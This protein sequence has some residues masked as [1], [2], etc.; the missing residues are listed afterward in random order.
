[1]LQVRMLRF[2]DTDN[3]LSEFILEDGVINYYGTTGWNSLAKSGKL[4]FWR[5]LVFLR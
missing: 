5:T 4:A 2:I 1:M 3:D